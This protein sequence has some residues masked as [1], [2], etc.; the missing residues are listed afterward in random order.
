MAVARAPR[1]PRAPLPP[2]P[3]PLVRAS[4]TPC[5]QSIH[6]KRLDVGDT[7]L[8]PRGHANGG[9]VEGR[10]PPLGSEL[11]DKSHRCH[12][13]IRLR[14]PGSAGVRGETRWQESVQAWWRCL[15]IRWRRTARCAMPAPAAAR[16]HAKSISTL[17]RRRS[18]PLWGMELWL[19]VP[20]KWFIHMYIVPVIFS[21]TRPV[22]SVVRLCREHATAWPNPCVLRRQED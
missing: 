9:V 1:A 7:D 18:A 2:E 10:A 16:S 11:C 20:Y 19:Q 22:R 12:P 8:A 6:A 13:W 17:W 15:R 14:E 3:G 4:D 21:R 5:G